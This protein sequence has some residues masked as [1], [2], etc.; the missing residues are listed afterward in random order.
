MQMTVECVVIC[1]EQ[2]GDLDRIQWRKEKLQ[3]VLKEPD[4]SRRE[5]TELLKFLIDHN[6][7]FT[8]EEGEQGEFRWRSIQEVPCLRD[9][10]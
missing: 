4:L 10:K 1:E 6:D 9:S 5:K 7:A 2:G 8:L 3:S